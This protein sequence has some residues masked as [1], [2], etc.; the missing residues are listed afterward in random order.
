MLVLRK[1]WERERLRRENRHLKEDLR[2]LDEEGAFAG[3]VGVSAAMREVFRLA[4]K[5]ASFEST[6]LITGE[7]GTGKELVARGIHRL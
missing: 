1:A 2:A 3:M 6:V 7:S 5:V 4:A